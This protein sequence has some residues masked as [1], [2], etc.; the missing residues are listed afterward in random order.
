[1]YR[2]HYLASEHAR[3]RQREMIAQADQQRLARTLRDFAKAS[4]HPQHATR[5]AGRFLQ[6]IR[7][8]LPA[9]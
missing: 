4:Q 2:H 3:D 6:R 7:R 5:P 8:A 9:A 1:M